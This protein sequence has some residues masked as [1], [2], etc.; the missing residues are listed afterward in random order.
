MGK[1]TL[2]LVSSWMNDFR[3]TLESG[4]ISISYDIFYRNLVQISILVAISF[5]K[6]QHVILLGTIL[7]VIYMLFNMFKNFPTYLIVPVSLGKHVMGRGQ[8]G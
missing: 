6:K 5:F 3:Y 2:R 8:V 4:G 1:H 7:L